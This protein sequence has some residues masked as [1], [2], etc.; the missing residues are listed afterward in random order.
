MNISGENIDDLALGTAFLSTGGG[1]DPYIYQLA[2]R[3]ALGESGSVELISPADLDDT[4]TVLSMGGTGAPMIGTEK[5]PNGLEGVYAVRLLEDYADVKADALIAAEIGGGNGLVPLLTAFHMGLPVVDADGMGRA[6]PET[7]M[8]TFSIYGISATPMSAVDEFG[9]GVIITAHD[10]TTAER[11]IRHVGLAMGGHCMGADH[12][13]NGAEVK[14]VAVHHTVSLA[15]RLGKIV[16]QS[17]GI[18][19]LLQSASPVLVEAGY[20]APINLFQGKVVDV[21]REMVGGYDV[22]EIVMASFSD[23]R[24]MTIKVQNEYLIAQIDGECYA[25]VPDLI[26]VVDRDTLLPITSERVRYGL[27]LAVIGIRAP[28][29]YQSTQAMAVTDPRAFGFDLDYTELKPL[30]CLSQAREVS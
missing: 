1:G 29:L 3:T 23:Q 30:R 13:M 10:S 8:M 11:I 18:D 26:C 28:L 15:T 27:R 12:I 19:E 5:L 14:R 16:R 4:A 20:G 7:Q 21:S 22:G 9:N 24:E 2:L 6:Y 17:K 25:T